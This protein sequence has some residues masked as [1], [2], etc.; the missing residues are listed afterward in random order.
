ME[1]SETEFE[2][3]ENACNMPTRFNKKQYIAGILL[4]SNAHFS[5][6]SKIWTPY[7]KTFTENEAYDGYIRV[8]DMYCEYNYAGYIYV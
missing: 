8:V 5:E 2:E 1:Q 4:Y 3:G 6:T 7:V